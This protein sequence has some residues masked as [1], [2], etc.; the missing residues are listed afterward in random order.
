MVI[1]WKVFAPCVDSS[2]ELKEKAR[3]TSNLNLD[4]NLSK[5]GDKKTNDMNIVFRPKNI[6]PVFWPEVYMYSYSYRLL[7]LMDK[8]EFCFLIISLNCSF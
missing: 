5:A 4:P 7:I 6:R 8:N 3:K 2:Q 1:V